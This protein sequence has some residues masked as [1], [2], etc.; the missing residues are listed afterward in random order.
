MIFSELQQDLGRKVLEALSDFYLAHD[1]GKASMAYSGG[2]DSSILLALSPKT[3]IPY[4]LGD[5]ISKDHSNSSDGAQK[6]GFRVVSI[7]LNSVALESYVETVRRID[8]G[9][10][11][12]DIGYEVVLAILLD[13]IEEDEL[14]TG[15]GADEIFYGYN[16]FREHPDLDNSS[17]MKKLFEETLPREKALAENYGK[18]L[19]TPYLSAEI[20]KIMENI[21][22]D[23]NFSGVANKAILRS[24]AV[25]AG[26]PDEMAERK[27]TAAQYGSGLMKKLKMLPVWN[28]FPQ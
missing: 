15:Q 16:I 2:L 12:K 8:P 25:Q 24:A 27:K 3:V 9:I 11:K 5:E 28:T 4:T 22:R 26:I 6:L 20:L 18:K 10:R 19:I 21:G 17:H 13:T 23:T 7:P 1:L 14:I